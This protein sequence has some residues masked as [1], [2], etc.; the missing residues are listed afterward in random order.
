MSCLVYLEVDINLL[1]S[2]PEGLSALGHEWRPQAAVSE[3]R[4]IY[5]LSGQIKNSRATKEHIQ[6][7]ITNLITVLH[8][9]MLVLS[10]VYERSEDIGT[11]TVIVD[12]R[13]LI[14]DFAKD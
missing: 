6:S 8:N 10:F 14:V 13:E 5:V 9:A 4:I 11:W 2:G 7:I 12:H 1:L 3:V